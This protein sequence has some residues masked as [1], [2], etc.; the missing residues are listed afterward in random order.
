MKPPQLTDLDQVFHA[1]LAEE[2]DSI[3]PSSGFTD[4]VMMAL[5]SKGSE[6]LRFPWKRALPGMIAGIAAIV[7]FAGADLWV[8]GRMPAASPTASAFN[9]QAL[10]ATI[11]SRAESPV[12][13]WTLAA[14]LIPVVSLWLT[15]RMFLS[16]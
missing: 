12:T 13:L 4:S 15:R 10:S 7:G 5:A 9:W 6:P 11:L 8:L 16:R 14:L 1:A 2:R 3:L